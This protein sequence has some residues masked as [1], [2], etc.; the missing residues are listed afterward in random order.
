MELFTR[1]LVNNRWLMEKVNPDHPFFTEIKRR[2]HAWEIPDAFL[3]GKHEILV[4]ILL[5]LANP[6][7][8]ILY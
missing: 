8:L 5:H 3:E 6:S 4:P 2:E 7:P 1:M